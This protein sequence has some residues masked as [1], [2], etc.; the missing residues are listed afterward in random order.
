MIDV[1]ILM[2]EGIFQGFIPARAIYRG[3]PDKKRIMEIYHEFPIV[4]GGWIY[5]RLPDGKF[6]RWQRWKE[7]G[8]PGTNGKPFSIV[9]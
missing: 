3:G 8:A 7:W 1:Y 9:G 6:M 2:R 5:R 4:E